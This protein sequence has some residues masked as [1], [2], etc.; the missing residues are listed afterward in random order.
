MIEVV[1]LI[2]SLLMILA[3]AELFTNGVEWLGKK[4]HLSEGA[5][6]SVLAAVGTALPETTIPLIA[7]LS[8]HAEGAREEIGIGAILGAP[9]MLST[10]AMAISGLAVLIFA[11]RAQRGR[12]LAVDPQV[13]G[14]DLRFFLIVYSLAVVAAFLPGRPFRLAV[15]CLLL[16][17]YG[18]YVR[19][20]LVGGGD[21]IEHELKPLHF[22][23]ILGKTVLR[24]PRGQAQ[25]APAPGKVKQ[26]AGGVMPGFTSPVYEYKNPGAGSG[27][28]LEAESAGHARVGFTP[29]LLQIVLSL[30]VIIGGAHFFVSSVETLAL[31]L[32]VSG[33]I[34]AVLIAPVATELPEKFNSIIWLRG[35]KDTLALGNITGAMVFQS[36][37]VPAVGITM[38]P[39]M[40]G[41]A[42][43]VTV[44]AALTSAAVVLAGLLKTGRLDPR[45]L[46]TGGVF[47]TGFLIYISIVSRSAVAG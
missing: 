15:A 28:P 9:F 12:Q 36:S 24:A 17:L 18:V 1:I 14:R 23:R 31:A 41:T 10:L 8:G 20:T 25:T 39:W 2:A 16:I 38:T 32:G 22:E 43:L 21:P 34:L 37:V 5:V 35:G 45:L 27:I 47:Y 42:E 4:L 19:R 26:P 11:S 3:G 13:L 6:G 29:I 40:L 44:L 30:A 7:F 33:F 46:L